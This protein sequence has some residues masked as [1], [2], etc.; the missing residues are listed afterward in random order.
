MVNQ[1]EPQTSPP[2]VALDH[3]LFYRKET[4]RMPDGS[5]DGKWVTTNEMDVKKIG[6]YYFEHIY[7]ELWLLHM[8]NWPP[9]YT[10]YINSF[11][12]GNSE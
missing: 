6:D 3:R 5:H 8:D 4:Y 9:G 11:M 10:M 2:L 7:P 1:P 12:A